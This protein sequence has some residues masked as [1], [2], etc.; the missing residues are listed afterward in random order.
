[1]MKTIYMNQ[2]CK[3][4]IQR[5]IQT[6]KKEKRKK[7]NK[8]RVTHTEEA[9]ETSQSKKE[10]KTYNQSKNKDLIENVKTTLR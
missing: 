8:V 5:I 1:M 4:N 3:H 6:R 2:K 10:I 9:A 7:N